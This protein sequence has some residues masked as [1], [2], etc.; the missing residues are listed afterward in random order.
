MNNDLRNQRNKRI[1]ETYYLY[2]NVLRTLKLDEDALK[3][4]EKGYKLNQIHLLVLIELFK[5]N[6][7]FQKK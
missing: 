1:A 7:K 5:L 2:G 4:Y 6:L 3:Q